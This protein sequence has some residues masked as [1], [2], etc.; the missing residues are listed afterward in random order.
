MSEDPV[1]K[2]VR[3]FQDRITRGTYDGIYR[4]DEPDLDHVMECQAAACATAFAELYQIPDDLDLDGFLEKMEM[5]GS[6]KIRI[7]REGNTILWEELHGGQCVCP[8]V[9][10]GVVPLE[11]GLCRCAVH[12]LRKLFEQHVRGPVQVEMLDSAALDGEN[13]VFRVSIEDSRRP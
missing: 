5:G 11:P 2:I 4:L 8:L 12:W 10:R 6:S 1:E 7:R 3:D 9:T 13:C